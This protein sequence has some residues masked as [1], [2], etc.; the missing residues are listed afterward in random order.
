M[1]NNKDISE[2]KVLKNCLI[3]YFVL[4][5]KN[6]IFRLNTIRSEMDKDVENSYYLPD[7]LYDSVEKN[8]F[9]NVINIHRLRNE[10]RF[11]E[12]NSIGININ[13]VNYDKYFNEYI[14]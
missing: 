5:K 8:E 9:K 4:A 13:I 6:Y 10:F 2:K 3:R 7:I 1:I 14:N 12:N 11:L